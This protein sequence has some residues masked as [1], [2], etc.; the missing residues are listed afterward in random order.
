[1]LELHIKGFGG[2]VG[3]DLDIHTRVCVLVCAP[4]VTLTLR[5]QAGSCCPF[6]FEVTSRTVVWGQ[7]WYW[8]AEMLSIILQADGLG[9]VVIAPETVATKLPNHILCRLCPHLL[10][11]PTQGPAARWQIPTVIFQRRSH[12]FNF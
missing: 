8:V 9:H 1:M 11:M 7:P 5:S 2:G 10:P 4:P 12:T 6:G 3:G